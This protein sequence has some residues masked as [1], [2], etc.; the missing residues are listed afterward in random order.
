MR[1]VIFFLLK[2]ENVRFTTSGSIVAYFVKKILH[3]QSDP[4]LFKLLMHLVLNT[5]KFS[6]LKC[7]CKKPAW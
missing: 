4:E 3:N 7:G 1:F 2:S 5:R 6:I